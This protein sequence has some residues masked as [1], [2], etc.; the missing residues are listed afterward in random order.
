MYCL[1]LPDTNQAGGERKVLSQGF[2]AY[3]SVHSIPTVE[4]TIRY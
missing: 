1:L 4:G 2:K 3:R